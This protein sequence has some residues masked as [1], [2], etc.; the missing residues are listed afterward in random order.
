MSSRAVSTVRRV[1][2][3]SSDRNRR[4]TWAPVISSNPRMQKYCRA[5]SESMTMRL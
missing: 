3:L 5:V 2:I 1:V 4:K